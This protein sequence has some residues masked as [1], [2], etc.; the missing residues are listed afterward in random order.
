[1]VLQLE[2][3]GEEEETEDASI[4]IIEPKIDTVD[5]TENDVDNDVSI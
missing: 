3:D 1:M 4:E 2:D 5:L